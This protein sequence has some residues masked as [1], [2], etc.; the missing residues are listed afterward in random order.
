MENLMT[1]I[2]ENLL[3]LIAAI[4]VFGIWLKKLESV[5]DNY[6]TVILMVFAITFAVLL[7]LIN[8]QYKVMYEAIVNAILQGILCWGVAVGLNQTYKQL[9]KSE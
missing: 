4:Y 2:P 8:S 3:I 7:N 9:N 1:F 5:K 6:I